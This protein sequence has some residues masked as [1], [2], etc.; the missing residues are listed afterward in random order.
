MCYDSFSA[1]LSLIFNSRKPIG[2]SRLYLGYYSVLVSG[3][4][5]V[6]CAVSIIFGLISMFLSVATEIAE[7]LAT[8]Y[9]NWLQLALFNEVKEWMELGP[10]LFE[11]YF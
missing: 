10:L 7:I 6:V 9:W 1:E 2:S 11:N 4:S 5:T 8:D 3:L